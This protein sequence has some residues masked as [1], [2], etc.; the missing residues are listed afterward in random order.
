MST[1]GNSDYAAFQKIFGAF[2][3]MPI[4]WMAKDG[5]V[6]NGAVMPEAKEALTLL[7]DWYGK[8]YIDPEFVTGKNLGEKHLDGVYAYNDTA[9]IYS[10]DESSSNSTISALKAVNPAGKVEFGTLPKGPRGESGGW[11]WGTAANGISF[12]AQLKDQPEKMQLALEI[13]DAVINDE[14]TFVPLAYGTQGK[15]WDFKN[16]TDLKEGVKYLPPYDDAVKLKEEG[17][18]AGETYFGGRPGF[19]I[20]Y[21]YYGDQL[22]AINEKYASNPVADI[23]GKPDILPSSGQYWG[24]LKKLKIET[25][26]AIVRGG[27]AGRLFRQL[28]EAVERHGR[29]ATAQGSAGAVRLAAIAPLRHDRQWRYGHGHNRI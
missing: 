22:V 24:D 18:K 2:G 5:Q 23:F 10:T 3:V 9:S 6:T 13:I 20:F 27:S 4:Q 7:A 29:R 19:D 11:S 8:G 25:Y 14:E 1:N 17:I 26:A 16:G 12:G 28:R 21:K 15:H